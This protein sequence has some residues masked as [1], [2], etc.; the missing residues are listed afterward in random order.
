MK[1][2]IERVKPVVFVLVLM[3]GTLITAIVAYAVSTT[4]PEGP[5]ISIANKSRRTFAPSQVMNVTAG[6]ITEVT[7]TGASITQ[8]WHGYYG[9]VT[10]TI[11]LDS[12]A[13]QSMYTW[14]QDYP[15]GEVYASEIQTVNW[16]QSNLDCYRFH[17]GVDAAD[18]ITID[19]YEGWRGASASPPYQ[20]NGVDYGLGIGE[21]DVDGVDETYSNDSNDGHDSFYTGNKYFNGSTTGANIHCPVNHPYDETGGSAAST[22]DTILIIGDRHGGDPSSTPYPPIYVSIIQKYGTEGFQNETWNFF[23]SIGAALLGD[24]WVGA[25][26]ANRCLPGLAFL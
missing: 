11:R 6:N 18:Y 22:F 26:A 15:S 7:V 20:Q 9:N 13:Q 4:E 23:T 19:E 8:S 14:D 24:N 3:L 12:A 21:T 10:G 17:F 2:D 1:K 5:T 16:T 25:T